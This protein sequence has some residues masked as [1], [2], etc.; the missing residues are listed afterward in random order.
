MMTLAWLTDIHLN[1]VSA[2]TFA[3]LCTAVRR[4]DADAILITGDIAEAD[5]LEG[6][7]RSL[8]DELKRPIYFVLGNHDYYGSMFGWVDKAV[9]ACCQQ[10]RYLQWL[11]STGVVRLT[12]TTGLVGVGGWAD[13]RYGDYERSGVRLNDFRYILDFVGL[14]HRARGHMLMSLGD[15]A[16]SIL[17]RFLEEALIEFEEVLV[18]THYPPFPEACLYEG[19]PTNPLYLPHFSCKA[20]GDVLRETAAGHPNR[21]IEVLCGHT[22]SSADVSILPNLHV[23]AGAAEYGQPW[24]GMVIDVA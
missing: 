12:G 2:D 18:A 11:Q 9:A 6:W 20:I 3:D 23:L 17:A 1:F 15:R 13:A 19:S 5:T 4:S 22:H 10:G 14:D 8:E 24:L 16:A 21:R 7:L